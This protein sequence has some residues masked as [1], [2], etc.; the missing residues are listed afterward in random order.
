[1]KQPYL[2]QR[3]SERTGEYT[4]EIDW[5]N[6]SLEL[7]KGRLN[8]NALRKLDS[9]MKNEYMGSSEFEFGALG[10]AWTLF[11]NLRKQLVPFEMTFTG[12]PYST[13]V[14]PEGKVRKVKKEW[15][16]RKVNLYGFCPAD[17]VEEFKDFIQKC[18]DEKMQGIRLKEY[19]Q[20]AEAVFPEQSWSMK[21][22]MDSKDEKDNPFNRSYG[23]VV[24]WLEFENP[25]FWTIR[26]SM[27]K[28][29]AEIFEIPLIS[30]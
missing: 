12:K 7:E 17:S 28:K 24:A 30:K 23:R 20:M 5:Q 18:V 13:W 25:A 14:V 29:V 8:Q 11:T 19:P 15:E 21:R 6:E 3:I 26:Q 10:E 2:I 9:F 27:H 1:M 16:P 4:K 22:Y